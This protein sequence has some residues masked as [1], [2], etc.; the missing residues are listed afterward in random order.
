MTNEL[1]TEDRLEHKLAELDALPRPVLTV[2]LRTDQAA[3]GPGEAARLRLRQ[4]LDAVELPDDEHTQALR[5]RLFDTLGHPAGSHTVM[6]CAPLDD[7]SLVTLRLARALPIGSDSLM[8]EARVGAPWL[9]PLRLALSE[10]LRTGVVHVHG[11]GAELFELFLG[12]I[13]RLR[14]FDPATVPGTF[15]RL[16]RSK[17]VHPAH[18]ADRG[19]SSYD[20]AADHEAAWQRGFMREV[21]TK[22]RVE[23]DSRGLEAMVVIGT[24]NGRQPFEEVM[25]EALRAKLI[26]VGPGLPQQHAGPAQILDAVTPLIDEE[27]D[28]RRVAQ[29]EQ[30][31][32]EGILGLADCLQRLHRGQ[33]ELL[34]V[35][36]D[37]DAELH[38]EAETGVVA[39]TP[40]Q[41]RTLSGR[42]DAEVEAVDAREQLVALADTSGCQIEFTR[43]GASTSPFDEVQ[44]VAGIA[45]WLEAA[46][47]TG[48]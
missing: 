16:E 25:P 21:A 14:S 47:E 13:T 11:R 31:Q 26:G 19:G 17:P 48:T 12:E 39:T 8:S 41:A 35:P 27:I 43:V 36:W 15:D 34:L 40:G 32:D 9:L 46:R 2:W 33:L 28:R 7:S 1:L 10:A 24:P 18:V 23:F 4:A 38:V 29:L 30:I 42:S 5:G 20:D 22:L 6:L 45:R 3:G 44:G 37:L